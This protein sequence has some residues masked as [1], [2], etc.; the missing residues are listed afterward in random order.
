N[1]QV[2]RDQSL[3]GQDRVVEGAVN[4]PGLPFGAGFGAHKDF[5]EWLWSSHVF[6]LLPRVRWW[7]SRITS[8]IHSSSR[9]QASRRSR[10]SSGV[11]SR[12]RSLA[13][14]SLPAAA[15]SR[16]SATVSV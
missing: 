16:M 2:G 4:R 14:R 3:R 12:N 8:S 10:H 5:E 15:R 11:I 1:C 9:E 7:R 6:V 13:L